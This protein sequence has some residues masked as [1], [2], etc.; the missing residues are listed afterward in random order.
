M[1][2]VVLLTAGTGSRMGK[3]SAVINKTLLPIRGKAIISHIIEQFPEDTKFVVAVGYKHDQVSDYLSLAHPERN[4]LYSY[5]QNFDG[6][7]AGPAQSLLAAGEH[8]DGPFYLIACDGYYEGLNDIPEDKNYVATARIDPMDSPAYCNVALDGTRIDTVV[9]KQHFDSGIAVSGVF[10]IKDTEHFWNG[11]NGIEL[12][13]GWTANE[14]HSIELPW[15]DLGTYER[16]EKF[17]KET[18]PF[19]NGKSDEF[20]YIVNNRVIKWFR[21]PAN[22]MNRLARIEGREHLFPK[23]IEHRGPWYSY[24]FV[25]G[26]VLYK[27]LTA[28]TFTKFL[29]WMAFEVWQMSESKTLTPELCRKFYYD[30]TMRRLQ[31]FRDKYPTF[32]PKIINGRVLK[33][34]IDNGIQHHIDWNAMLN[35]DLKTRSVFFHGDL[36]FD[37]VIYDGEKFTLIDWRQDFGG[38]IKV[39]DLYYDA[40]KL[41]GGMIVNYDYIRDGKFWF[42]EDGDSC[43]FSFQSRPEFVAFREK[44]KHMLPSPIIE[45]IVTLIFLNMAPLHN[46]PFDKLLFC[47]ALERLNHKVNTNV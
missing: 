30:K 10:Y 37:N 27:S 32:N 6:P 4:F 5:V 11:L 29:E 44:F 15:V 34:D 13:S 45:D 41:V 22:T 12:A 33:V 18:S 38:Q 20:L 36:Q 9:D 21:N 23:I 40:A 1:K 19:D 3:Y 42:S 31:V 47:L 7:G 16:Y 39:G 8:I 46:A 28:E 24:H 35:T 26:D 25:P 14:V 2:T 17:S 43:Y